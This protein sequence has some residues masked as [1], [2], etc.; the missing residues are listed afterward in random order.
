MKISE[1]LLNV[2]FT[3]CKQD[4]LLNIIIIL[5][6]FAL[7]SYFQRRSLL[8]LVFFADVKLAAEGKKKGHGHSDDG[9]HRYGR[10]LVIVSLKIRL[11]ILNVISLLWWIECLICTGLSC[12]LEFKTQTYSKIFISW[13]CPKV[14]RDIFLYVQVVKRNSD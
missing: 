12:C 9:H 5:R 13:A 11:S 2:W 3:I 4:K 6:N 14:K 7:Y 1:I 10:F 8:R